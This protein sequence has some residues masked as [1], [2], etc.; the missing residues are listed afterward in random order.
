MINS[1]KAYNFLL[2]TFILCLGV[3]PS[4]YRINIIGLDMNMDRLMIMV[5]LA[6]AFLIFIQGKNRIK[7]I[8]LILF[9]YLVIVLLNNFIIGN[10]QLMSI[11]VA[12]LLF[13][14]S[15][16]LLKEDSYSKAL[17]LSFIGLTVWTLYSVVFFFSTGSAL[18]EVP[19]ASFLPD[20]M[21]TKLEHAEKISASYSIFPR[22]S[23]PYASPPQLSAVAGVFFLFFF[24]QFQM[25]ST[26]YKSL[27]ITYSLMGMIASIGIVIATISRTGLAVIAAGLFF[28]YL[29]SLN[30]RLKV[31]SL[32]T[33]SFYAL[34]LFG[35]GFLT[36]NFFSDNL[37][38]NAI[39]SRFTS[40]D[41]FSALN[42]YSHLNI[43]LMGIEYFFN[44]SFFEK[45]FGIG[46]LNFEVLHFHSSLLTA[47]IE[48][49]ILGF[50]LMLLT[51]CFPLKKGFKLISSSDRKDIEKGKFVT[52]LI[53]ALIVA[54]LV[55]EVP[56]I[57]F[58]WIFWGYAFCIT[59][60]EKKEFPR[61]KYA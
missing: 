61:D 5:S 2:M 57:Q 3:I 11:Y 6:V 18:V 59:L 36:L 16:D 9:A 44:M 46:Y 42:P 35:L 4:P 39:T 17:A 56:Y 30:L 48:L 51:L 34:I 38:A 1:S 8:Q 49:G 53:M 7:N 15:S 10:I 28:Y 23:F 31:S 13:F 47:L 40:S 58:L 29:F 25:R 26:E 24:Y 22:I 45:L 19:F 60:S 43:R 41:D 52:S 20:F 33:T 12:L 27:S 21:E 32:L 14:L 37:I 50:A 55:Y 54:H